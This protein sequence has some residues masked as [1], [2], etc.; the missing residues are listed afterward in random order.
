MMDGAVGKFLFRRAA[1]IYYAGGFSFLLVLHGG[2]AWPPQLQ[3]QQEQPQLV[4]HLQV[5]QSQPPPSVAASNPLELLHT[6]AQAVTVCHHIHRLTAAAMIESETKQIKGSFPTT[7]ALLLAAAMTMVVV[8]EVASTS[9]DILQLRIRGSYTSVV[10]Y[11]I[12]YSAELFFMEKSA[13]IASCAV[14]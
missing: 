11:M 3:L 7:Y 8:V 1:T 4:P 10:R 6:H 12:S 13:A 14:L 5:L 2:G 9:G